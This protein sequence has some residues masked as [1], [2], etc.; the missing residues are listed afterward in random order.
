MQ[1]SADS[2]AKLT[3]TRLDQVIKSWQKL[4]PGNKILVEEGKLLFQREGDDDPYMSKRLSDG[5]KTV[6][7]YLGSVLYAP[8]NSII[9]VDSPSMFLHSAVSTAL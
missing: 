8:K 9:F 1:Y 4:F 2:N 7:F 3:P 5:E 6:L